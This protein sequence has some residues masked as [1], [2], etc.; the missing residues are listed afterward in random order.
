MIIY[1]SAIVV[2]THNIKA[3]EQ[4]THTGTHAHTHNAAHS[5]NLKKIKRVKTKEK[6]GNSW[7][8]LKVILGQK[9]HHNH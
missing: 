1:K 4:H 3:K 2:Y 5:L 7:T 6:V 9:Y 8:V